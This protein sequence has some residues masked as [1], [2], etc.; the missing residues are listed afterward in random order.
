MKF[1]KIK[2]YAKLNLSLGV[3][4]KLEKNLHK[5]ESLITFITLHDD[6]LVKAINKKKHI[7]KF[8]GKFSKNLSKDNSISNLLKILDDNKKI[9]NQKYLIKVHKKIPQKSGM[10]GG[11]M[12]AAFLLRYLLKTKKFKLNPNEMKKISKK[13]GSDL[14]IG[15]KKKNSILYGTGKFK[16]IKRN[17]NLFVIL[18]MPNFGCSTKEIYKGVKNYSKPIFKTK[19]KLNL[20]HKFFKSLKNDLEKPAFKKYPKLKKIKIFMEKMEKILFARMTGSGSTIVGYF[21]SK[22]AALNAEKILKKKYK[23]YWCILSKTI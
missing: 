12:N 9:E 2:S 11:S 6:I 21:I 19:E 18:L 4:R 10:A 3:L 17:L 1:Y 23:N 7:I 20:N 5:I 14:M 8:S 22:K 13:I 15:M 16:L